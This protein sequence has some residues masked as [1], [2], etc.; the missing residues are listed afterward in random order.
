MASCGAEVQHAK[1][2][3]GDGVSSKEL[4]EREAVRCRAA[5]GLVLSQLRDHGTFTLSAPVAVLREGTVEAV[6]VSALA[7]RVPCSSA[8]SHHLMQRFRELEVERGWDAAWD[9]LATDDADGE[10]F[11]E[12]WDRCVEE[13]RAGSVKWTTDDVVE[14]V[15]ALQ[16]ELASGNPGLVTV[17][18][19][20]RDSVVWGVVRFD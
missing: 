19:R 20:P 6:P 1:S 14:V 5:L 4:L 3:M 16:R 15:A 9:A 12:L 8:F 7:N 17:W 2:D 10:L 11:C 13:Q 18:D